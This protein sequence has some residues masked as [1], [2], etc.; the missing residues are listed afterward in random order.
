M[1]PCH[2]VALRFAGLYKTER[3]FA[4]ILLHTFFAWLILKRIYLIHLFYIIKKYICLFMFTN[5]AYSFSTNVINCSLLYRLAFRNQCRPLIYLALDTNKLALP[6]PYSCILNCPN[7]RSQILI[8]VFLW[9]IVT[10]LEC[11]FG[12]T[13]ETWRSIY[14]FIKV[15]PHL[16]FI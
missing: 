8:C 7:I 15:S 14:F 2:I 3:T 13:I 10:F 5:L 9:L 11:T 4:W 12:E 6:F 16:R 1:L